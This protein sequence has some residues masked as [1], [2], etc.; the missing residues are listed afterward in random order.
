MGTVVSPLRR[1]EPN[2]AAVV[3]RMVEEAARHEGEQ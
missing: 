3:S 1:K 2:V